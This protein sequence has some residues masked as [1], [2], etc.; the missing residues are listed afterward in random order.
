MPVWFYDWQ[1]A[2]KYD[3]A[4]HGDLHRRLRAVLQ[5]GERTT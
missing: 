3:G 4:L 2:V 1:N 5:A